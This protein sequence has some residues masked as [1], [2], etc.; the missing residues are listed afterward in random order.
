[1]TD[2][3]LLGIDW[4]IFDGA[5]DGPP[6]NLIAKGVLA[7]TFDEDTGLKN[8]NFGPIH[9][10][11]ADIDV[12]LDKGHYFLCFRTVHSQQNK[13]AGSLTTSW[14]NGTSRGWWR[15]DLQADGTLTGPW[16]KMS[17]FNNNDHEWAFRLTGTTGS[18]CY[19]DCDASG[20]L[21][22][23]DFICFQTLFGLGDAG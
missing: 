16:V 20:E 6:G 15:F 12:Q 3:P 14:Q 21:D 19:A 1:L 18:A 10:Q 17:Q 5:A 8:V 11:G 23:D 22:V 4:Y 2:N 13:G 9:R 7:K